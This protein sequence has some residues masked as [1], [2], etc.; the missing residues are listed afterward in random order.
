MTDR[1][2]LDARDVIMSQCFFCKHAILGTSNCA[3]FPDGIPLAIGINQHDHRN[4]FPNDNGI[5]FERKEGM[6][7]EIEPDFRPM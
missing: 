5:T 4:E 7:E 6:S 1:F 2:E 3:A